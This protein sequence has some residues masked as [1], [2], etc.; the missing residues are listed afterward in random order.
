MSDSATARAAV[1]AMRCRAGAAGDPA[2]EGV[3]QLAAA[4][5]ELTGVA[6]RPIG[7][8]SAPP[9]NYGDDLELSRGCLLEAGGQVQDALADGALP[10]LVARDAAIALTTLPTVSS[11]RP[12]ARCLWLSAAASFHTPQSTPDGRLEGMA[13]A[14]ACGRWGTGFDGAIA[15]DRLVLCGV[16]R[17]DDAERKTIDASGVTVIGSSLET[18]VFLQNALDGGA[19]YVHVDAAVIAREEGEAGLSEEKIFDLLDAVGD[20]CEVVGVQVTGLHTAGGDEP[21]Q[22]RAERLASL[23]VPVLP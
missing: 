23:L 11:L 14:G 22:S 17:L 10:V 5:G 7:S 2:A 20:G 9:A 3:D 6:P 13:L 15:P 21:A 16:G 19:V 12:D 4:I 1:V 8:F 18:L